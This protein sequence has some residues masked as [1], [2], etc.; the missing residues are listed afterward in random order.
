MKPAKKPRRRLAAADNPARVQP[1]AAIGWRLP[2][3]ESLAEFVMKA[4]LKAPPAW[5]P[6]QQGGRF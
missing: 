6:A 3:G 5:E 1:S 2:S 4:G